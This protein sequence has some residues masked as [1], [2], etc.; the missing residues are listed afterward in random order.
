[1]KTIKE[2]KEKIEELQERIDAQIEKEKDSHK[3]GP[4]E[5]LLN[6]RAASLK[7]DIVGKAKRDAAEAFD[8]SISRSIKEHKIKARFEKGTYARNIREVVIDFKWNMN[9]ECNL[10]FKDILD[11]MIQNLLDTPQSIEN[12]KSSILPSGLKE[13]GE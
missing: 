3:L 12:L 13:K 7:E 9:I 5:K 11:T 6:K 1:M 10:L 8:A 2:V 4:I